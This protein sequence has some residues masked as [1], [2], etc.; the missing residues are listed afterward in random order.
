MAAKA[1][2]EASQRID[3]IKRDSDLTG[4]AITRLTNEVR[5]EV[6]GK[7]RALGAVHE[8]RMRSEL[9][10]IRSRLS[11]NDLGIGMDAASRMIAQRDAADRVERVE[12]SQQLVALRD[13]A[14][15]L[16]D[17]ILER[18]TLSAAMD[19]EDVTFLN[20]WINTH[21]N[22]FAAV[23]KYL[24]LQGELNSTQRKFTRAAEFNFF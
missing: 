23:Q 14:R 10:T 5:A 4:E 24:D 21:P 9:D 13:R 15:R 12:S 22:D 16:G 18:A 2:A 20:E 3:A 8:A 7:L 17:T 19:R 6:R 1:R 11:T